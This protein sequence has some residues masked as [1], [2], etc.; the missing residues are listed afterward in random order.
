[1][2]AQVRGVYAIPPTPFTDSDQVDEA[3]LRRCVDSCLGHG[4][5]GIVAAVNASEAPF[6]TDGE[7]RRVVEVVVEQTTRR[8]SVGAGVSS[9][10][11]RGTIE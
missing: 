7:R 3:S 6:L 1:M 8:I 11:T 4:A 5:H 2:S 10:S 9:T